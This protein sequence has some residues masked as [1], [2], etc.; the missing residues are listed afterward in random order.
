M[1]EQIKTW[2]MAIRPKTLP[3]GAAP[4]ILGLALAWEN[5]LCWWAAL[6]TLACC[7][8]LQI[9]ANL[10]ND[11][12]DFAH[13]VDDKDRL[14]PDRVTQKGLLA[15]G[16]VRAAF[17][18]CFGLAFLLGVLLAFRGGWVIVCIGLASIATAY[19][20]TGG[21]K[22]LSYLGLGE[23]FAFI[24]FGPVAVGGTYYLQTLTISKT[25]LVAAMGPGFLAAMLMSVNNL[26]DM[27][28]DTRTGK[29]TLA[30]MLGN[31]RTR[32]FS[33]SL[34]LMSW[35]IPLIYLGDHP[36]KWIVIAA[37][38]SAQ[39][40]RHHWTELSRAPIGPGMNDILAAVGQFTFVYALL[41]A[42]GIIV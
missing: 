24:F 11:Y 40:F 38:L 37:P 3:A 23:I 25:V 19:L 29:R 22:P 39:L 33:L 32:I 26:R 10:V 1:N 35:L 2:M 41:F 31:R 17:M 34:L 9:G 6:A 5:G 28:S 4:V 27:A 8:L 30:I 16:R 18:F 12:F 36:G 14:G 13:G 15:P 20:Y 7:M 42:V 21:P